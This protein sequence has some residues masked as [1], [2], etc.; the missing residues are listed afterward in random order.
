MKSFQISSSLASGLSHRLNTM[1]AQAVVDASKLDA[2][3]A[4]RS[5]QRIAK[6]LDEANA[7]FVAA[8]GE[9][10]ARKRVVLEEA[11]AEYKKESEGL[12]DEAKAKLGRDLTARFNEK[13]AEIQKDSKANPDEIVTVTLSDEDY[14]SVLLPVFKATAQLWDVEGNGGGQALFLKVADAI[15]TVVE[16]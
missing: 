12:A 16:A 4:I 10:E 13:A 1:D 3:V 9:I 14:T 8:V 5:N 11:Q 7:P 2:I 6:K 15:E